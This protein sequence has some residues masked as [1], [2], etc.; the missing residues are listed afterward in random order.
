MSLTLT[1]IAQET[2]GVSIISAE[3]EATSHD[4]PVGNSIHFDNILG[5][6]W[7][8]CLVVV[9]MDRVNY[10]DSSAIG[11]LLSVHKSLRTGGGKL[12]LY[13][14]QPQIR[15]VLELLKIDRAIPLKHDLDAAKFAVL[16]ARHA[17]IAG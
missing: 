16:A 1:L 12:A 13:S 14:L 6:Q 2:S 8:S 15:Q 4:F 10:I 3:G 5:P 7:D 9:D 11:W 17:A